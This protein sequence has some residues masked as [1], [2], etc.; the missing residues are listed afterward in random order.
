MPGHD[1]SLLVFVARLD[2]KFI[3]L[4]LGLLWRRLEA[5]GPTLGDE[6]TEDLGRQLVD[7]LHASGAGGTIIEQGVAKPEV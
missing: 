6:D 1:P 7:Q 4:T 2:E 5:H 3:F